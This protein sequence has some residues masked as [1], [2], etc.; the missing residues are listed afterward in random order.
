MV[1]DLGGRPA[2][3]SVAS[4]SSTRAGF[5]G[6]KGAVGGGGSLGLS[7]SCSA[8][9]SGEASGLGTSSASA[10]DSDSE[11]EE[12]PSDDPASEGPVS[13]SGFGGGGRGTIVALSRPG[14]L[15]FGSVLKSCVEARKR[16]EQNLQW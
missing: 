5:S 3:S 14:G 2:P 6:L 4:V 16:F 12:L 15:R 11:D 7:S 8:G 9:L 13:F 10:S 1:G